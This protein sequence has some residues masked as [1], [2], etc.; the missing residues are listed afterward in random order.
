MSLFSMTFQI[1]TEPA[2]NNFLLEI[3]RLVA[4]TTYKAYHA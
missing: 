1:K 2:Q 3:E 4:K